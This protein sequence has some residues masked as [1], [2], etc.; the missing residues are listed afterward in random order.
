MTQKERR[1]ELKK[2][3]EN[4]GY[5]YKQITGIKKELNRHVYLFSILRECRQRA[6]VLEDRIKKLKKDI[7]EEERRLKG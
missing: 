6:E 4:V 1:L 3:K 2:N 5:L 7:K